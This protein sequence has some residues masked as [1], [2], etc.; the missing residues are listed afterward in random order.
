M[1]AFLCKI[2]AQPSHLASRNPQGKYYSSNLV[3]KRL[4]YHHKID[5]FDKPGIY[6]E[7]S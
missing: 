6:F 7:A 3:P 5:P 2:L 1:G 4:H